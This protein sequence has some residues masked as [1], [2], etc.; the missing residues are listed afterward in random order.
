MIEA[1]RIA[2]QKYLDISRSRD[3]DHLRGQFVPWA[4]LLVPE[5][6]RAFKLTRGSLLVTSA[7]KA[8]LYDVE[9]A[10]LQ[11][12]IEVQTSGQLRYVDIS[13]QHIFIVSIFQL[14][15][16]DRANRS[17]VLSIAAGRLPWGAYAHPRNQ[18]RRTEEAFNH[19]ELC[20][21]RAAP[22][23]WADRE[24]YFNAG[25]WFRI[26][27]SSDLTDTPAYSS[28]RLLLWKTFGGHGSE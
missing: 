27:R 8:Y 11:Q 18:W 17:C 13:E 1:S 19:G 10:E 23:N 24:D 28:S 26:L 5:D 20:F 4:R 2:N 22:P 15:V 6:G 14:N 3:P 25:V 21:R 12:T 16:Y 7:Q 9:K